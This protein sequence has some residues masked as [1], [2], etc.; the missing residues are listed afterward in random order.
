M[1]TPILS[2]M[3]GELAPLGRLQDEMNRLLEGFFEEMPVGRGFG[4]MY[5]GVNL[6]EEEEA[7]YLEAELPGLTLG[8]I[9]V[10]VMGNAVSIQGERKL[11]EMKE[12]TYYRRERATG[13]FS[14]TMTLP[15]EI[16]AEKVEAK[17]H[18]GILTVRLPKAE[19]AKPK[20]IKVLP[21]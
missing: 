19:S 3:R 1:L 16:N 11:P 9:E 18:E 8:D 4:A 20:K 15:W 10:S 6:W 13:R 2:P 5:P 14:R 21:Q 17:L 12:A 7:A